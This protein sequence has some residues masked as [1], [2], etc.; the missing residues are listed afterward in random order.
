MSNLKFIIRDDEFILGKV[1]FH[2]DLT[3]KK[4]GIKGGGWWKL[5]EDKKELLLYGVSSDFGSVSPEQIIEVFT[6]G[7]I[8]PSIDSHVQKVFYSRMPML[9][10]AEQTKELIL[11][12]KPDAVYLIQENKV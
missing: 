11:L 4:D 9:E 5:D 8:P 3:R 6:N 12:R 1:Q 2:A 10:I 7:V